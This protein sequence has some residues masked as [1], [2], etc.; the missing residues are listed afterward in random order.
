MIQTH[1]LPL[2][3]PFNYIYYGGIVGKQIATM[4][5]SVDKTNADGEYALE[6]HS[7]PVVVYTDRLPRAWSGIN[8]RLWIVAWYTLKRIRR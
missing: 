6:T 2:Q 7:H 5:A 3:P 4:V 8:A 1:L